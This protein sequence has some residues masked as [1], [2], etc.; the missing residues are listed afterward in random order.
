MTNSPAF[1]EAITDLVDANHVLVDQK[2]LDAYGHVSV[3]HPEDPDL[4]LL[5]RNLAPGL[6]E[7]DDI[8][9]H[10]LDGVTSDDR[11]GYLER[12]IHAEIYRARPDVRS[13]VH[14]HSASMVPFSISKRP[15]EA[16]WHMAG[17]LGPRVPVFDIRATAGESTDLLIR[18]PELGAALANALGG[19]AVALM[20][21]HGSVTVGD[22]ISQSVHRAVFAELNARAL[23]AAVQLGDHEP[24]THGEAE[25]AARSNDGQIRRAWEV[26]RAHA[27]ASRDH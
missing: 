14:S 20:R 27:R 11:P 4:F 17:F 22:S 1:D 3:R 19:S 12:F 26:W 10:D 5:S 15:L 18:T 9:T 6:V 2:V 13:V 7:A 16:V 24:L 8:Q 21:G 23:A 25:A